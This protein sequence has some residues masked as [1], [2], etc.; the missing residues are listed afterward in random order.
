M[1]VQDILLRLCRSGLAGRR[2]SAALRQRSWTIRGGEGRGLR[3]RYPGNLDYLAGSSEPP[4]QR[5]IAEHLQA[6]DTFYDVG[7]NIGFF[8]LIAARRVGATGRVYAFEPVAANIAAVRANAE[9]NRLDRIR[10]FEVAVGRTSGQGEL[11]LTR[12]NGGATL[13]TAAVRPDDVVASTAVRLVA[14]DDLIAEEKLC[15]P[16][17]VK[18]DVEGAELDVLQGLARTLAT[19]KPVLLYEVD[20]G[21]PEAFARRQAE[22]DDVVRGFG[23]RVVHLEDAYPQTKWCVGHSLATAE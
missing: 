9:L 7:A 8:S 15:P 20:D 17:F 14:L 23:Y 13:T 18:I 3:I 2:V 11:L 5:A 19:A 12:W 6:G 22:L 10:A 21:N 1:N 4:V 16:D